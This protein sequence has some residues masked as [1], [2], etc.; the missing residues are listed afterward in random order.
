MI[1]MGRI[2]KAVDAYR[3]RNGGVI[4]FTTKELIIGLYD[5]VDKIQRQ[6]DYNKAAVSIM[7][8]I[9]LGI[10]TKLLFF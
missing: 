8:V 7:G 3:E 1:D 10:I 6:V 9:L 4:S 5:K 2:K